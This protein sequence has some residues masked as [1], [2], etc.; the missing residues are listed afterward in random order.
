MRSP[1]KPP[2]SV[3]GS[4]H[5]CCRETYDADVAAHWQSGHERYVADL[6]QGG[7]RT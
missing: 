7:I 2:T 5:Q 3:V 1:K 6:D 4:R